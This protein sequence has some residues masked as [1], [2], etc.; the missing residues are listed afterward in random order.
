[1]K[2][3]IENFLLWIGFCLMALI[4]TSFITASINTSNARDYHSS[5]INE[6]EAS[7]FN[8]DIIDSIYQN[9]VD[10]GYRVQPIRI[11]EIE[12]HKKVA[13]VILEYT[14]DIGILNVTGEQHTIRGYAR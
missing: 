1:M 6:I 13:E 4:S 5:I 9:A 8:Q 14:Y 11:T 3:I 7:N 12:N 10:K 2:G